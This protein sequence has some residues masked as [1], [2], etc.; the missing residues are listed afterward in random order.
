[1]SDTFFKTFVLDNMPM[2]RH[3]CGAYAR[4][5][6]ELKDFIQEVTIQLWRSHEKFEMR[7]KI[8]TW[9]YR[10]TLNVCLAMSRKNR[11]S[12][13]SVS[14]DNVQVSEDIDHVEKEQ[15]EL[16]YNAVRKL[17][18]ADRAIVLLYLENK[19][20]KEIAEILG[21]TVTNVGVKVNRL[22]TQLKNIVDGRG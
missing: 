21:M 13:E 12:I 5:D 11:K 9:V 4:T 10:V 8:S 2:I 6:E 16:L 3:I 20:Y 1:M 7:A 14:L 22:K 18:E 15:I 19:S 17:K